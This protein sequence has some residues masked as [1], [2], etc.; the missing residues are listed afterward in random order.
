MPGIPFLLHP[1][2][3]SCRLPMSQMPRWGDTETASPGEGAFILLHG[4]VTIPALITMMPSTLTHM[5]IF[6]LLKDRRGNTQAQY[7][8]T[9]KRNRGMSSVWQ[10]TDYAALLPTLLWLQSI[11]ALV[12][13]ISSQN[14]LLL[15]LPA[16]ISKRIISCIL[17][18]SSSPQKRPGSLCLLQWS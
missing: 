15:A 12:L 18:Q 4:A 2:Q 17:N 8:W 14:S 5:C 11:Y 3:L 13:Q 9:Q 16:C 10:R 1:P 6:S 7:T